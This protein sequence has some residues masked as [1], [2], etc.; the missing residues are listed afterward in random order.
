MENS[1]KKRILE[2]IKEGKISVVEGVELLNA[3]NEPRV[4]DE[5]VPVTVVRA[6][7]N[8]RRKLRIE[9]VARD[10]N[11]D[12]ANVSV[13]IPLNIVKA[14]LPVLNSGIIP[15]T[16]RSEMSGKGIDMDA[17][18][19]AIESVMDNLDELD[20]DIVSVDAGEGDEGAKVKIYVD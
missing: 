6:P 14:M 10:G 18:M 4:A 17:V 11:N 1:D 15:E 20:E 3:I 13:A 9:V 8:K 12:H 7:S 16:A 19:A 5:D 2:M